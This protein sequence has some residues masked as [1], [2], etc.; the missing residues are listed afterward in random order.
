MAAPDDDVYEI[1]IAVT[2]PVL[3]AISIA[4]RPTPTPRPPRSRPPDIARSRAS[5][6]PRPGDPGGGD[7]LLLHDHV[8]P[9]RAYGRVLRR[10]GVGTRSGA[11]CCRCNS[12]PASSRSKSGAGPPI[13]GRLAQILYARRDG[14]V[15]GGLPADPGRIRALFGVRRLR[16]RLRRADPRLY[17]G[18]PRDLSRPQRPRGECRR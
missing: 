7:L 9:A 11:K 4:P 12:A 13:G 8:D 10:I 14:R 5:T 18:D 3:A 15:D 16:A 6:E 17:P 2:V 1:L